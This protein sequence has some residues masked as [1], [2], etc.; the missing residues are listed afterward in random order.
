MKYWWVAFAILWTGCSFNQPKQNLVDG[1]L[2]PMKEAQLFFLKKVAQDTV[3]CIVNGS[4]TLAFQKQTTSNFHLLS[5]TL[6]GYFDAL[7]AIGS[8][9]G[10]VY[11]SSIANAQLKNQVQ[12]QSSF[13]LQDNAQTMDPE[14]F[15]VHPANFVLY[16]PFDP[17]PQKLPNTTQ[18]IPICDYQ[19]SNAWARLEWIKA[20]GFLTNRYPQA[21][22]YFDTILAQ[23]HSYQL[24]N[25]RPIL[26]GSHDGQ[27]FYWSAKNSAVNQL[28]SDAGFD[29]LGLENDGNAILDKEELWVLLKKNPIVVLMVTQDQIP[30]I[31]S[32]SK[33]WNK[34]FQVQ[35]W[36]IPIE[37]TQYFEKSIVH[38]EW[39]LQDFIALER[40]KKT[41]HFI[42]AL[43]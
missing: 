38:P 42:K 43:P 4:D 27:H 24:K 39:L 20:I 10:V 26:I 15:F 34:Q 12:D 28:A 32:I 29:V 23:R 18:S 19:E 36:C 9:K 37:S 31:S 6:V 30:L 40:D 35:T 8:I 7:Q 5:T 22:Q 33:E 1:E 14:Q 41:G 25:P 3:L 11:A 2:I 21:C 13:S 16:S 17:A